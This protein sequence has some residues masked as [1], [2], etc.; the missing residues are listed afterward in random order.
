MSP[1]AVTGCS[2]LLLVS[3]S[4]RSY[5]AASHP[6]LRHTVATFSRALP[7]LTL[8][9]DHPHSPHRFHPVPV[10]PSLSLPARQRD[11]LQPS[12]HREAPLYLVPS[13]PE[14]RTH[15]RGAAVVKATAP[16]MAFVHFS[17]TIVLGYHPLPVGPEITANP[18]DD[19]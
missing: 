12:V 4:A 1:M 6:V 19:G 17:D 15:A 8:S 16:R 7:P 18:A 14:W 11:S 10:L 3:H 13:E 9:S 2:A 5:L